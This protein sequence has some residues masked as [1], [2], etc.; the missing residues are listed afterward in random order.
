MS[1][2]PSR[3]TLQKRALTWLLLLLVTVPPVLWLEQ[4]GLLQR[5]EWIS[6]DARLKAH[7][8]NTHLHPDIAVV[9]I[10]E[11]SLVKMDPLVG[12]WPWPRSVYASLLQ[13]F[14]W[15]GAEAV[16]FDI[17]FSQ[18]QKGDDDALFAEVAAQTGIAWHALQFI[19]EVPD[20]DGTAV[21]AP[22]L[23]DDMQRHAL[24]D[25]QGFVDGPENRY[26]LP[27]PVH[28]DAA[29]GL[30]VVTLTPDTDSVHRRS[31]LFFTYQGQ[32]YPT[33]SLAPVLA[34]LQPQRIEHLDGHIRID[35]LD[36][37]VD[38]QEES[39]VNMVGQF[40][41]W[42]ISAIFSSYMALNEGD[43]E[44]ATI[45]P[46]QFAGKIVFIGASA[47]GLEDVKTTP[48]SRRTPGVMIQASLASNLL[49]GEILRPA[50]AWLAPLTALLLSA[51]TA[52]AVLFSQ[53]LLVQ[54]GTPFVLFFGYLLIGWWAFHAREFIL[55]LAAPMLAILHTWLVGSAWIAF[56]EGRERRRVRTMFG[57]YVSP[58]MLEQL[59]ESSGDHLTAGVGTTEELTIL[60]SDVRGF[61]SLSEVLPAEQVVDLLNIH[62]STMV[63][64]IFQYQGTL[65][66]FIGDAIMAFWGAPIRLDHHADQAVKSAIVMAREM[67]TVNARLAEKNY[68]PIAIGIGLNTGPMVLGNI[69]SEK[70][71]D[72]TVIGDNVNLGSRLEGLTKPYGCPIVISE[73]TYH[74]LSEAIPCAI[75]DL[76]RVKG[77]KVP[78]GVYWPMALPDDPE[79]ERVHAREQATLA[80]TAFDAYR[81]QRWEEAID[82]Y[83]R[84]H[85]HDLAKV[86]I[87]R[88]R[89]YQ[90]NPPPADWDGVF[91]MT[92]K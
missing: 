69:G 72:Y 63:E 14:E 36:L 79:R 52:S 80:E 13:Y 33:L 85:N 75:V 12:R 32:T 28:R 1:A 31:H 30:G 45:L 41:A 17:L 60:F 18:S 55:T 89:A 59:A 57:Q 11:L 68:P 2:R 92:S 71:L 70:K 49:S 25:A 54:H 22:P 15:G 7:R 82:A 61:T 9:L 90:S 4:A 74:A 20:F 34:H 62:L 26:E 40:D 66:K 35:D 5:L 48:V 67:D 39:L 81:R 38:A 8:A 24:A 77:K 76:V 88:C 84:L 21:V 56:T 37:A 58:A 50:P 19:Q 43:P 42:S 64:I 86:F 29:R 91:T 65:D 51:L 53:R 78:I 3:R 16:V 87:D 46:D 44:K 23:P 73:Y 83:S 27:L 47:V 6:Y 10:D